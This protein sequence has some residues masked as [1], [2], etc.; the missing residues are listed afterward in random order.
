MRVRSGFASTGSAAFFFAEIFFGSAFFAGA[1]FAGAFFATGA[2]LTTRFAAAGRLTGTVVFFTGMSKND[3]L[4]RQ[5]RPPPQVRKNTNQTIASVN[6]TAI[7]LTT[8]N[9]ATDGPGSAEASVG[10]SMI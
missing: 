2:F 5:R 4:R 9:A 10:V 7:V 6:I 8:S 3:P 1:F